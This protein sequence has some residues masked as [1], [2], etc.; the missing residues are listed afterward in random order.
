M[1]KT[2]KNEKVV[3]TVAVP[4]T[5]AKLQTFINKINKYW[6]DEDDERLTLE[7]VVNDVSLL[8]YICESAVEDGVA[9]YD[10]ETFAG[11]GD[12]WCDWK[13]YVTK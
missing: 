10:P 9:M 2:K 3:F 13:D 7:R 12:G 8:T 6:L 1:P 4:V 11:E 5:D